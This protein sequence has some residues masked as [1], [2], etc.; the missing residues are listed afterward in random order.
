M[1]KKNASL[2]EKTCVS[3][4]FGREITPREAKHNTLFCQTKS[5]GARKTPISYYR[6]SLSAADVALELFDDELLFS[7]D[8]F[9]EIADG[10]HATHLACFDNRQ[11]ADPYLGH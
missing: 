5:D 3:D 8:G 4:K 9:D 2:W 7:D 11:M 6:A 10:N 1:P